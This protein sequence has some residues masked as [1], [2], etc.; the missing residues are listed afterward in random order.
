MRINRNN[1]FNRFMV[2]SAILFDHILRIPY[3]VF[4]INSHIRNCLNHQLSNSHRIWGDA[5]EHWGE[6][7]QRRYR[8][9]SGGAL[10]VHGRMKFAWKSKSNSCLGI[11]RFRVLAFCHLHS[12][13]F[14]FLYL[15]YPSKQLK[16]CLWCKVH[17][18]HGFMYVHHMSITRSIGFSDASF[19]FSVPDYTS[20]LGWWAAVVLSTSKK[21][22]Q[23]I[24]CHKHS[25]ERVIAIRC[26]YRLLNVTLLIPWGQSEP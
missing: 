24:K 15:C 25:N 3:F 12:L 20:Y 4:T 22:T 14:Q 11:V 9:R 21:G 7:E 13:P 17:V 2:Q 8:R 6:G 1:S 10:A 5:A 26:R 18:W 23:R 16:M 19:R